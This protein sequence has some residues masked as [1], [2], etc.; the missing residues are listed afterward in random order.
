MLSQPMRSAALCPR[1]FNTPSFGQIDQLFDCP[2]G[3]PGLDRVRDCLLPHG[4][5]LKIIRISR[6]TPE[7]MAPTAG[8]ESALLRTPDLPLGRTNRRYLPETLMAGRQA[9]NIFCRLCA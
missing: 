4:D 1:Q 7:L 9:I 2:V 3:E 5:P 6:T 8:S